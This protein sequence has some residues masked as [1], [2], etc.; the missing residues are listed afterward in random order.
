MLDMVE[1]SADAE[2]VARHTAVLNLVLL[3]KSQGVELSP[4]KIIHE[5]SLGDVEPS[6][7]K[8][9]SIAKAEGFKAKYLTMEWSRLRQQKDLFPVIARLKNGNTVIVAG[10]LN[11]NGVDAPENDIVLAI[12]D[13]LANTSRILPVKLEKFLE[14]WDHSVAII[15]RNWHIADVDQPFGLK[16][17]VPELLKQKKI[18]INIAIAAAC[19]HVV[20][21]LLP[22]FIQ[23]VIDKVLLHNALSTLKVLTFG[24]MLG[25]VFESFFTFIRRYFLI[26]A[27]SKIDISVG[28][29]IFGHLMKLPMQYFDKM[30]AGVLI[31]HLQQHEKIRDFLTGQLFLTLLDASAL[32]I[33]LP[34]L[35]FYSVQLSF[36]VIAFAACI[37]LVIVF[38]IKPFRNC[39]TK[40]YT[41]EGE[42]QS[43]LVENIHGMQTIKS[44]G[45]EPLQQSKWAESLSRTAA[46]NV[47][48]GNISS[49][50]QA[51]VLFL[52]KC[53]SVVVIAVGA[54]LVFDKTMTAGALIAF[55][56]I[57]GR[58]SGPLG[59]IVN[60]IHQYQETGLSLV[61]LGSIMNHPAEQGAST[62]IS[63]EISGRIEF[64][65]VSFQ[66]PGSEH[67]ALNN[68][69]FVTNPNT[70][71]GIVGPSGSGKSTLARL[72][73]GI[74]TPQTGA[75][76]YDGYEIRRLDLH[77]VRQNTGVV[78][79]DGY[80]FSGSIKDNIAFGKPEASFE[81][82]V[83]AARLAGAD[84]FI[85]RM[86]DGYMSMLEE[87]GNNL[88]GGQRQRL[89]I[90]RALLRQP[91]ILILD[92]ATS[93]LDPDSEYIV[94]KNL[95]KI[96]ND[97]TLILI[98]HKLSMISN[99]DM[100]I[101]L[102]SGRISGLGKHN[103]LLGT[104]SLYRRMWDRQTRHI[105]K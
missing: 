81:E 84:E 86:P 41:A 34:L 6:L 43:L 17:F 24:I 105:V 67:L 37:T 21:L 14:R 69:S 77:H 71:L 58:V 26:Y 97:R 12:V 2:R 83:E 65:G 88:S 47:Q 1:A 74:Y 76:R 35:F 29:R 85:E 25:L 100:I 10:Y 89:S 27:S 73:Q 62:G 90:A 39:V 102:E 32:I 30:R 3:A 40:L 50:A 45:I 54:L 94:Q 104:C 92:E 75:I 82:I 66:Y 80:I 101:V 95:E 19:L 16:W 87:K 99:A 4:L 70:I 15:R 72:M 63:P 18:F 20:S 57:S 11:G 60:L 64:D 91:R 93:A 46:M 55:N 38:L 7:D 98:S 59:Q 52:E 36:I 9:V 56:I 79:Q 51:L 44:L 48:V 28:Y 31:K 53:M 103:E 22:I 68:V 42:K 23:I 96:A 61:M 78:L 13:P 49:T 8:L 33:F 5:H